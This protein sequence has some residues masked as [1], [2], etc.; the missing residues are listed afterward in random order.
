MMALTEFLSAPKLKLEASIVSRKH[1]PEGLNRIRETVTAL[2]A[3]PSKQLKKLV[4][5]GREVD[6][7]VDFPVDLGRV[8][9]N[10]PFSW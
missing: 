4:V 9:T 7:T 3:L 10:K 8:H 6:G 2:L 1:D 5:R